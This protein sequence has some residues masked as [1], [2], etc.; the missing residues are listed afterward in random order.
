MRDA[1]RILSWRGTS[2]PASAPPPT[3][4]DT[5]HAPY[6]TPLAAI[7]LLGCMSQPVYRTQTEPLK[8]VDAVDLGRYAGRWYEIHRLPNSF[9]DTDCGT[10]TAD[11]SLRDDGLIRVV[12]S[13]VKA[14]GTEQSDGVARVVDA[15]TRAKLEVS[16]FRP[17]YGDY[18]IVE[19][20]E[21]YSAAVIAEP[22]G[23]YLWILG[24]TPKLPADVSSRMLGRVR[25][26]GYP[27]DKLISP[28]NQ[29]PP[30]AASQA[31]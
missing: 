3:C 26:L 11:Y 4:K 13:C 22:S 30:P 6:T 2:A 28:P 8:T 31:P 9:E 15:N 14:D 20:M 5:M 24:R 10:V 19:L 16:F 25:A 7:V 29:L 27:L 12:N 23:K 17:F 21:D 18:W 1:H